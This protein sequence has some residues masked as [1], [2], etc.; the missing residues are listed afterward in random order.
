MSRPGRPKTEAEL[1]ACPYRALVAAIVARALL[2]AT[3]HCDPRCA[4]PRLKLVQEARIWLRDEDTVAEL[5]AMG[6]YEAAPVLARIRQ[7]LPS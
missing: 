3:G 2:D 5:L 6:G 7:C 1:E 4:Q